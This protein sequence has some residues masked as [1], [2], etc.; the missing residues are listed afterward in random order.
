M[1]QKYKDK[2]NIKIC[3]DGGGFSKNS[4][5][6]YVKLTFRLISKEGLEK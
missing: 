2:I 3:L 1:M 5:Y 4:K 6:V